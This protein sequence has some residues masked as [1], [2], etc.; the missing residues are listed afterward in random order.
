MLELDYLLE[1]FL[2]Q[3]FPSLAPDDQSE[4]VR[5]LGEAD[6]DLQRW[7]VLGITP[8][9]AGFAGLIEKLLDGRQAEDPPAS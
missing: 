1:E 2:D 7:L 9:D 4:F 3:Q 8:A 5:L 6:Q